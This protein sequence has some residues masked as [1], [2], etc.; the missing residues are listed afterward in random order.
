VDERGHAFVERLADR[1]SRRSGRLDAHAG[2]Y[3]KAA[4]G[5][6]SSRST[7]SNLTPKSGT[8]GR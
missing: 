5:G 8:F 6:K 1:P 4:E 3:P 2:C 7:P